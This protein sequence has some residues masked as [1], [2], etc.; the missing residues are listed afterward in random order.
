MN[1]SEL[2]D[3]LKKYKENRC[4]QAEQQLLE[5]WVSATVFPEYQISEEDLQK[6][7]AEIE[8]RIPLA[9]KQRY[10]WPKIA[11]AAS[12]I[13]AVAIGVYNY[14]KTPDSA[15][16]QMADYTNDIAPGKNSA[17][18]IL[19]NGEKINLSE[20][21]TGKIAKESGIEISK[22]EDGELI[23]EIKGNKSVYQ[24]N[25]LSTANGE[26]YQVRLPDGTLV[27]LNSASRLTYSTTLN[28]QGQRYVELAGEAYFEV[29]KDPLHPFIVKTDQQEVRV[30]GTHF[31]ISSYPEDKAITTTLLEGKV[32]VLSNKHNMFEIL[33]P[34]Q[35]TLLTSQ[36][37]RVNNK[38]DLDEVVAWKNGYF[39]FNGSLEEIMG[40]IARW[41]DVEV[42]Y[43][44]KPD[45]S[46]AFGAEISMQRNISALLKIIEST[47]NVKFKIEPGDA[48]GKGR[49]VYVMK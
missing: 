45:A 41:Y 18:L 35:Q 33:H 21:Q 13:C 16:Q 28:E 38:V 25:T 27:V 8:A 22:T 43:Q 42:V 10:L 11:V 32:K 39:K 48:F 47:G 49:R 1:E 12:I 31:N 44:F 15:S 36:S 2:Q 6:D 5:D 17:T 14:Y 40:K 4:T 46:L 19:A 7:L 34:G 23:Y 3:L 26:T 24:L 30:L 37:L 29:A 20:A 9:K